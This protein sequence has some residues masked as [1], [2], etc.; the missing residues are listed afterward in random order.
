M[1]P[2]PR[3]MAS[4]RRVRMRGSTANS[5]TRVVK[6]IAPSIIE[7]GSNRIIGVT[8]GCLE[9]RQPELFTIK[10]GVEV[11][12]PLKSGL[13]DGFHI[14]PVTYSV[15]AIAEARNGLNTI[16]RLRLHVV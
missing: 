2:G 4:L 6:F 13:Q 7:N 16:R 10:E 11:P 14:I 3:P 1:K 12:A 15:K 8:P 5:I 9:S